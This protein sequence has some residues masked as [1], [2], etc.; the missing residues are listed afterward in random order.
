[1]PTPPLL[2]PS[3][4]SRPS[5][6]TWR[7]HKQQ[8][9]PP[10]WCLKLPRILSLDWRERSRRT[11]A[12][13]K[14]IWYVAFSRPP[15]CAVW[16]KSTQQ[17]L[18]CCFQGIGAYRD[19]NAKPWVLPVVKKVSVALCLFPFHLAMRHTGVPVT[20]V[21]SRG[22]QEP[23]CVNPGKPVGDCPGRDRVAP[24]ARHLVR[25]TEPLPQ[26]PPP[27]SRGTYSSP[28]TVAMVT[29]EKKPSRCS[30]QNARQLI[31]FPQNRQMKSYEMTLKP[32][33]NTSPSPV[34]LP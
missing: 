14:L 26:S 23:H 12:P 15:T 13:K 28:C 5:P 6:N 11:Q 19:E 4:E 24:G 18:I 7:C 29:I 16:C 32:T 21:P 1:M 25:P 8:V 33:T 22:P 17:L 27:P 9:S 31:T 10:R 34:S 2:L 20:A 3:T 30:K